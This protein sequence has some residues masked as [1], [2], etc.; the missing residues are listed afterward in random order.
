ME[1][2]IDVVQRPE[3]ADS[4]PGLYL[5]VLPAQPFLDNTIVLMESQWRSSK[6]L[7]AIDLESRTLRRLQPQGARGS[8]SL[9]AIGSGVVPAVAAAAASACHTIVG[10][11]A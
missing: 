4:F 6:A 2:I 10:C 8:M 7:L 1:S 9:L 5:E 11:N 3:A